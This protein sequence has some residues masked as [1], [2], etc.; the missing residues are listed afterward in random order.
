MNCSVK[1]ERLHR[2]ENTNQDQRQIQNRASDRPVWRGSLETLQSLPEF[3]FFPPETCNIPLTETKKPQESAPE[4]L[5]KRQ[6]VRNISHTNAGPANPG[7]HDF[8]F[9]AAKGCR[10]HSSQGRKK[11]R[12]TTCSDR[13]V[14][15]KWSAGT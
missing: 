15:V 2:R 13:T 9:W 4:K 11:Q 8:A 10:L 3:N 7:T 6:D 5:D 14:P 1:L 12:R